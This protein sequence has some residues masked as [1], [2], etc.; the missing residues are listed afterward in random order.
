MYVAPLEGHGARD[1]RETGAAIKSERKQVKMTRNL[2][3]LGLALVAMFA[4]SAVASS[5]AS[6]EVLFHSEASETTLTGT[7]L[8]N[9]VFS[10]GEGESEQAVVCEK[11]DVDAT[12]SGTTN[13]SI[14]VAPKY[15]E[16]EAESLTAHVYFNSCY[17]EFTSHGSVHVRCGTTGDKIEV[18]VTFLGERQCLDIPAQTPGVSTVDYTNGGEGTTRDITL[19]STAAGISYTKTGLCGSGSGTDGRY[20]GEVTITGEDQEEHHIGIWVE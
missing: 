12:V 20:S 8:N 18:R 5:A 3:A 2:K 9:Q 11:I 19:N 10:V 17:Y 14:N 7:A 1:L 16:C 13:T 6:A 4:M 15:T